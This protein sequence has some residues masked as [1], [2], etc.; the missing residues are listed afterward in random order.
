MTT[1]DYRRNS[2]YPA[3]T[4]EELT[5]SYQY[6]SGLNSAGGCTAPKQ[7][8]SVVGD[9][10]NS[11]C[12]DP[13]M[14]I[15]PL[16]QYYT[17]LTNGTLPSFVFIEAGYGENDEH[18]GSGNNILAGQTQVA[19]V[20]NA[21]MAS[22]EW[23]DSVFFLAY[24]EGGGPYDHVPPAPGHSNATIPMLRWAPFPTSPPSL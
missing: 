12:I 6:L 16:S 15:A 24:D 20:I 8:S 11:F 22:P 1:S 17:D 21:F 9:T 18:P 13:N 10:T 3:S 2:R 14:Y 7:P 23:S 5:Y 19:K 4:F